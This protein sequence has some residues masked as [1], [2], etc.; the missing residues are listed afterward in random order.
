MPTAELLA[1]QTTNSFVLLAGEVWN[2]KQYIL[3]IVGSWQILTAWQ[4][5]A[6]FSER[7]K[8]HSLFHEKNKIKIREL[9]Y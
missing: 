8:I 1:G 6:M 4:T 7:I 9:N 3:S 5:R 2:I